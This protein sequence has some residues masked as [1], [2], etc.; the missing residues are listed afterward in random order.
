MT[1]EYCRYGSGVTDPSRR[2]TNNWMMLIIGVGLGAVC[3]TEIICSGS[4]YQASQWV[5][6]GRNIRNP[7]RTQPEGC[8]TRPDLA[9]P[10][11]NPGHPNSLNYSKVNYGKYSH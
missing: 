9:R 7:T 3:Y 8:Q 4:M 11:Q 6:P 10:N 5:D 2:E 1:G